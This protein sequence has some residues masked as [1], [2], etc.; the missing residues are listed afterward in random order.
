VALLALSQRALAMEEDIDNVK[1]ELEV[2]DLKVSY[3]F[4]NLEN[5]IMA[6]V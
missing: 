2:L 3:S 1:R 5:H 6:N 4:E